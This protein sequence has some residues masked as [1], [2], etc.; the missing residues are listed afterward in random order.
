MLIEFWLCA[1]SMLFSF[2]FVV[3]GLLSLKIDLPLI[4][5]SVIRQ[6]YVF[7]FARFCAGLMMTRPLRV[8]KTS[9]PDGV[10][11][12]V[13]SLYELLVMVVEYSYF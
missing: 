2:R 1:N 9:L 7:S 4:C 10:M 12:E 3:L 13:F 5:K 11:E 8:P 6:G